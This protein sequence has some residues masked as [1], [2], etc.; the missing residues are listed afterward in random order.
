MESMAMYFRK[1]M[2]R[3]WRLLIPYTFKGVCFIV[4]LGTLGILLTDV[5]W[6]KAASQYLY[7]VDYGGTNLTYGVWNF[8]FLARASGAPNGAHLLSYIPLPIL[9][10]YVAVK[11]RT[12]MLLDCFQGILVVGFGVAFHELPWLVAYWSV[13]AHYWNLGVLSNIIEDVGFCLMC[14][15]LC[16]AYWKYPKRSISLRIFFWPLVGYAGILFVWALYGLPITTINNWQ[17]G[18]GIFEITQWWG[19]VW[20][21][22]VEVMTWIY[23]AAAFFVV[24]WR[25]GKGVRA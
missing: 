3:A 16:V 7:T 11:F 14:V 2:P 18:T 20:V 13:Y 24:I 6:A 19:N 1:G 5:G 10:L 25:E 22:F 8:L 12:D 17:L 4:L 23:V 9:G 21:N 15:L